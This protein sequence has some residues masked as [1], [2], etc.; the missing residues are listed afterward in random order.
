MTFLKIDKISIEN[1]D[2]AEFALQS[3]R[4]MHIAML[5]IRLRAKSSENDYKMRLHGNLKTFL[6]TV[7]AL[8]AAHSCDT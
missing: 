4:G 8:L 7:R 5:Q 3:I 1:Y 2:N 6:Q